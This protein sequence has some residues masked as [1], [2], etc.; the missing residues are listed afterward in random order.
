MTHRKVKEKLAKRED[1][2][3]ASRTE[4]LARV[5]RFADMLLER[6]SK[7]SGGMD[8]DERETRMLGN[9]VL[10]VLRIWE[11]ALRG[12]QPLARLEEGLGQAVKPRL[13]PKKG[14]G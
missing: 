2:E 7:A 14:E 5:A 13:Q 12:E 11:K 1:E 8:V 9:L 4:F 3:A 6:L 10:K